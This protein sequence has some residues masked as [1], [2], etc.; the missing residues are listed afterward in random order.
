MRDPVEQFLSI[1][2]Q[3]V[4]P[5]FEGYLLTPNYNKAQSIIR[6]RETTVSIQSLSISCSLRHPR[7]Q[8]LHVKRRRPHQGAPQGT[9][10]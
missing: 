2:R 6:D 5:G 1:R 7:A 4:A 3:R 10:A 8:D 9:A